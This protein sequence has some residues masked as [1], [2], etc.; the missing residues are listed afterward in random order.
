MKCTTRSGRKTQHGPFSCS[1]KIFQ[2]EV[3]F[4]CILLANTTQYSTDEAG[5]ERGALEIL[6]YKYNTRMQ[7]SLNV[8]KNHWSCRSSFFMQ[9]RLCGLLTHCQPWMRICRAAHMWGLGLAS[10]DSSS[11]VSIVCSRTNCS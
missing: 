2:I 1:S 9:C 4:Y 8:R 3:H 6:K 10:G 5:F 11:Y 7:R